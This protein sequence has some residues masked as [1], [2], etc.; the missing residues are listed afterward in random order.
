MRQSDPSI[1]VGRKGR[2][3]AAALVCLALSLASGGGLGAAWSGGPRAAA[4]ARGGKGVAGGDAQ[5]ILGAALSILA[6][7]TAPWEDR[8]L[9]VLGLG[10]LP[11]TRGKHDPGDDLGPSDQVVR[12]WDAVIYRASF[13]V[14]EAPAEDLVARVSLSPLAVWDAGQLAALRLA[15][16]PGGAQLEDGGR[17]LVCRVGRV[18]A[19]PAVTV[20]LDLSAR[21]SG[22]ALQGDTVEAFLAV[23]GQGLV[24]DP[25]PAGC[26][27]PQADGCDAAAPVVSVSASPAAELRK[28]L[29]SVAGAYHG[30]VLGRQLQWRLDAVLGADGDARG[31]SLPVGAPW[32]LPDWWRLTGRGSRPLDLPVTLVSCSD[33]SGRAD[34]TCGQPGGPGTPLE[35]TIHR[36]AAERSLPNGIA[37]AAPQVVGQLDLLLWV[38]EAELQANGGDVTFQ[39]CFATEIGVPGRSL[40]R[41]QDARGQPNLGG[42]M[43]PPANNC[44]YAVLPVPTAVPT[45]RPPRP[46]PPPRP[47]PP[48]RPAPPP[49]P[50]PVVV[51]LSK[52]YQPFTQ[53]A[54]V[55]DGTEFTA[56]VRAQ[57][58]GGGALPGLV[59]CDKWDN[60]SHLLR[61][62]GHGGF[63]LWQQIDGG[64]PEPYDGSLRVAVEAAAG[65][66]GRRRG[67]QL[68]LGRAWYLQATTRCDDAAPDGTPGWV[69]LAGV[70]F[71]NQGQGTL[72]ARDVNLVRVRFL[73]GVPV[74]R[75][76]W[77]ELFLRA[78]QN[79]PG[80]WLMNYGTAGWGSGRTA[81]WRA[82]PCSGAT[83]SRSRSECPVP[84]PGTRS[85]PGPL[86]D[87]LVH[88]G[89][90]LW[91]QKRT[92]PV[93]PSGAPVVNA[94]EPVRFVLEA[95]S[96]PRP[97]DPPLPPY[98][99]GAFAPAVQLSDVLPAGLIYEL[100]SSR[101]DSED[102]NG[103][104][105]LD[106][107]EDLNGN[108]R[109]D[110]DVPF[111]PALR[112]GPAEGETTL[113]WRIGDLPYQ[114][115]V[116]LIRYAART[117]RL[118]RGGS[119]LA[120]MAALWAGNDRPP[121]CRPGLREAEGGRCA[122]AQVI[123]ANIAAAQVEKLPRLPLVLP[124]EPFVYRLALANLTSRPVEWFDAV[125]LLPRADG[126]EPREPPS[127]I[128][129]GIQGLSAQVLPGGAPLEVWASAKD[130]EQLDV[131][132][133]T[134]RDGLVDPVAAWGAPGAG[135][136]GPDWPCRLA[137]VGGSRCPAIGAQ[138][139]VTALRFWGPDPKPS[140]TGGSGDS[141]LPAGS[142]PRYIDLSLR[143]PGSQVGNLAHNAWGGR[144]ESLP[145]PVFDGAVIR[146][147]PP[148]TPTPTVTPIPSPTASPTITPS[149]TL[150]VTPSPTLSP[151]PTASP[152]ITP[153]PTLTPSPT[154]TPIYR[155]Y[156]PLILRIPCLERAV[157]VVLVVDVSS[158]MRRPA[159]DG[160]SK[161][162]A[163]LRAARAFVDRFQPGPAR[164]R[165][166]VVAFNQQAWLLQPLT[167]DRAALDRALAAL[168]GLMAEGTR[169]DL[170][171]QAG[172]AALAAVEA[173][174]VKAMV[175]LTDGLPN[176]VP[177][178]VAGGTQEDTVLAAAAAAR[179]AGILIQAV[180]YGRE[181][182]PE[183]VDRILPWL[184]RAIAGPGGGYRET[185]DAGQLAETFR[186]L[187]AE[188][189]CV[190]QPA[191]P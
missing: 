155:I 157:D 27:Q 46:A 184:L 89:V 58:A 105:G 142:P 128:D 143:A 126:G 167:E 147:R 40:W 13:S 35:V 141:F 3:R 109:L 183:L 176:R 100:G 162:D 21:V 14:R 66:W 166:A 75:A 101:I 28:V 151:T 87:M 131:L 38:P 94:G 50:A 15:G 86:G 81:V 74:A 171:L 145:L 148:D 88:V 119:S 117:S 12:S 190:R 84:A 31:S 189:G 113:T 63:R 19:P 72:D 71:G 96:Y 24:P 95:A 64:L 39:N 144:F 153:S 25:D 82:D 160:G 138:A 170:G 187:A 10:T 125:D 174:R 17:T 93:A 112:A 164:G 102:L 191:W 178:P 79:P 91:L 156:L 85:I 20:A 55:T 53:G 60:S 127:R 124:G 56:E 29:V 150:T 140:R 48:G 108:G 2:R 181:D 92:D 129:G 136:G 121:D 110:R 7:G 120:N 158:S 36:I 169:L 69:P 149:P 177:T 1:G 52:R 65:R 61:D 68:S 188:L 76:V 99:P 172:A 137:E 130:P 186:V 104:G 70:D 44:S 41:P 159:G 106:P 34:W 175:F 152:T 78:E 43:E 146:V 57:L 30:G 51:G 90:P 11:G 135:L 18:Q 59:L 98:P 45:S 23:R 116:P 114:R 179:A 83:G 154:P 163:V 37:S 115:R 180:G 111:E 4:A 26:A 42:A 165:V 6:D 139:A 73:D 54:G 118:L 33:P 22:A 97:A 49:T 67:A 32:V 182:A 80:T 122:W 16:C 77:L 47:G 168:P 161:L 62:G 9:Q 133:G 103:S 132:G 134:P 173:P 8:P 185:D 107:G 123:V 5:A